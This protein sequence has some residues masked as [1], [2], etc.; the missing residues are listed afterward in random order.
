MVYGGDREV[1]IA[2]VLAVEHFVGIAPGVAV[3]LVLV[4]AV[5]VAVG[6]HG[7]KDDNTSTENSVE[8]ASPVPKPIEPMGHGVACHYEP[9]RKGHTSVLT[10][11]VSTSNVSYSYVKYGCE[12]VCTQVC[13][14]IEWGGIGVEYEQHSMSGDL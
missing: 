7:K 13:I 3:G 4:M 1:G 8:P 11:W 14:T 9:S 2:V 10:V 6:Y 5:A 12:K